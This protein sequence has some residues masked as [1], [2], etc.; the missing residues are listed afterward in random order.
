VTRGV[1]LVMVLWIGILLTLGVYAV[2]L[3]ATMQVGLAENHAAELV[4][5][6]AAL[7]GVERATSVIDEDDSTYDGL[8]DAW[9]GKNEKFDEVEIG[10]PT[11]PMAYYTLIRVS[12]TAADLTEP[13]YGIGDE[14]SRVN[15]N[16][17]TEEVLTKLPN[18]TTEIAQAILDWRDPD[19]TPLES[20]AESDTYMTQTPPYKARNGPM[21]TLHEL[22][23]VKGV[24]EDLFYGED[25]NLN[26]ILDSNEDDGDRT[27][28][29]DNQ[30]GTLNRGLFH[31]CTV[32]S[33]D[34]NLTLDDKK[35]VN[36]NTDTMQT[37][38]TELKDYLSDFELQRIEQ[39]RGQAPYISIGQL[40]E[41]RDPMNRA[42][43]TITREDIMKMADKLTTVDDKRVPGL[44]N[45]L[46]APKEV[47]EALPGMNAERADAVMSFRDR[48]DVEF[49]SLAEI[50][51]LGGQMPDQTFT[52]IAPLITIRSDQFRIDSVGRSAE[53]P[54][55][56]R[57][58]AVYDRAPE[59]A[60]VI[61]LKEISSHGFPYELPE[62][63]E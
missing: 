11:A 1:A 8:A 38:R 7:S 6:Q 28:P 31:W 62:E 63:T 60:R 12:S 58:W 50:L 47:L 42:D 61:Y 54:I 4:A 35:R 45:I 25:T 26:G 36:I 22:L 20:G 43:R 32:W 52:S 49:R 5:R 30:D 48:T 16:V 44:I 2:M 3:A 29:T 34:R 37:L 15:V 51:Q 39:R 19:D 27:P 56:R 46:T 53:R 57:Y 21:E 41:I 13:E 33:Y 24:T 40:L 18:M 23:F 17:A 9:A 59:T 10:D 14:S 55:F